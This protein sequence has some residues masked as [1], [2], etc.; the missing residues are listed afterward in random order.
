MFKTKNDL[1]EATRVK[2][3]ELL[4]ARLADCT[5]LQTQTKQAHW[6]VKGP[7]FIALHELFDKINEDVE[8]YVDDIAERAVQLGGVAE[9]TA[10]MVARKSSLSEYPAN[11]VDGRSHVEALSSALAAFGKS[12]RKGINEANEFGD[13]DTADLFTEI[14]RGIDKWLWF[15]EAHLQAER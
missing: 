14:S 5:D 4:N 12:A 9:G 7:N 2:A 3:I 10:R 13:L 6:N 11:T 15:V 1:S 8:D